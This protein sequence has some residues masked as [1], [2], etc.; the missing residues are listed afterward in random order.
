[1]EYLTIGG[2]ILGAFNDMSYS[3]GSAVLGENDILL[4][5]T[6]GVTEAMNQEEEEFGEDRLIGVLQS[7]K[8]VSV[9]DLKQKILHAVENFS[10]N[11][12]PADDITLMIVK[13]T[14]V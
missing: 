13:R 9:P 7:G 1:M 12:A 11:R 14:G 4:M 6:D 10:L 8:T 3:K 5:Y 2:P